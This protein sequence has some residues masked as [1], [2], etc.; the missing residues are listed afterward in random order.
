MAATAGLLTI[1]VNHAYAETVEE[2]LAVAESRL[3][4]LEQKNA[5][6]D[7]IRVNGFIRFAMERT[8]DIQDSDGS[9]LF[10]RGGVEADHW[11]NRRLSRAGVQVNARI[12]DQAEAVV[13][14]LGRAND[15]Y[16]VEAH[17]AYLAYNLTPNLKLRAGRLVLPFYLHSQYLNV[18]Y[19]YPWV[20]LPTE[21]Y[22][23]IPIDTMEGLDAS[24]M[25]QTGMV[26]H[27][28]NLFYGSMEVDVNGD[29]F[30][31]NN[32]RG[33][34][35]R[36]TY[37]NISTWISYTSSRVSLDLGENGPEFELLSLDDDYAH[38]TGIGIQ[39]DNGTLLLMAE[40]TELKIAAPENW[41][42]TQP[43]S[44]VTVGYRFGKLMPHLTWAKMDARGKGRVTDPSADILYGTYADRQKSWTLGLRHDVTSGVAI[45]AEVSRYY[46]FGSGSLETQGVFGGEEDSG[47]PANAN[48]AVFRLA[49]DAVF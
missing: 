32:Q 16:D 24:W 15:D 13:Q 36:S 49:V 26:N 39:Y 22:G 12:S 10:F 27:T 2:R 25:F 28:L 47:A 17:W 42:P 5:L 34:N 9:K 18:G 46:D 35:L 3:A 23:A 4:S 48:P 19:A 29:L 14:L 44:Y 37:H 21:I 38:Y 45:K 41:F 33:I 31:V 7:R 30:M 8:S 40:T 43:A 6:E 20:E 11:N 1:V